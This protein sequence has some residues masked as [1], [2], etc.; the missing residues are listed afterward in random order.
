MSWWVGVSNRTE[1]DHRVEERMAEFRRSK[2][3]R[4]TEGGLNIIVA[5][6]KSSRKHREL[7]VPVRV[8]GWYTAVAP[9][10]FFPSPFLVRRI[11]GETLLIEHATGRFLAPLAR[12]R[13]GLQNG[14]FQESALQPLEPAVSLAPV[15]GSTTSR[16]PKMTVTLIRTVLRPD[17]AA[18]YRV[19]GLKGSFATSK[20]MFPNGSAPETLEVVSDA[21][22]TPDPGAVAKAQKREER[23]ALLAATIAERAQKA[24][25]RAQ[26]ATERA[27]KLAEQ[28]AKLQA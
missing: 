27:Q 23:K 16:R 3:G 20:S 17:G 25:E 8:G 26:K 14:A 18:K 7:P 13:V 24:M 6:E 2:F 15:G 9:D 4:L 11:V 5:E 19:Q 10:R 22:P 21:I 28:A 12:L 1:F